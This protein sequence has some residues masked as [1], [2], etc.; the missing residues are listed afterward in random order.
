MTSAGRPVV[1]AL[2]ALGLG[3][4]LTGLP[5]LGLIK[6]AL[7]GHE[8]V[9]AAPAVFAPLVPL[10][11]AVDR[12]LPAAE[13]API[14]PV[15]AGL[16]IAIDLHGNGPASRRLLSV[17][18]PREL[19]GFADPAGRLTGP[20]WLADE[21][22]VS[23]W[24]RLVSEVLPVP[25]GALP[26]PARDPAGNP[27]SGF[28]A[29]GCMGL[30]PVEMPDSLTV[31]HPGAA[32]AARRWP[33][34]R[35]AAVAAA[36]RGQG[37]Q[38]VITGGPAEA[39]LVR[40]VADDAGVPALLGLDL[41]ELVSL[42]GRARLVICGDTGVAHVASNYR[43][44]S[45]LLFGPVSP[46]SWGPPAGGPHR[47][48][49]HGDGTGNPHGEQADPALLRITVQ[50]VLDAVRELPQHRAPAAPDLFSP[51]NQF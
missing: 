9:L 40:A 18:E 37:H 7:P 16:D 1:L 41:P 30:P 48:L 13:L 43:T 22:E 46:A 10:I 17:L 51:A 24:C 38:V 44:P 47:V 31:L 8:V 29:V 2:R 39:A 33:A 4:F 45:V 21:H 3:D 5:A 25:D 19:H 34:P 23:R 42:I 32:A 20:T 11:P 35:F 36:L 6:A 28:Q 15:P 14:S 27:V 49:W 12:L 50:E 26:E